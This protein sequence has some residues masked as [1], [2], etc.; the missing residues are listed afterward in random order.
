MTNKIG[1]SAGLVWNYLADHPEAKISE[2]K[3]ALKLNDDLLWMAIGWLAR[4]GQIIF[5]GSG[6]AMQIS[7]A[8]R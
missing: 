5:Q 4:E 6:K 2:I 8:S 1:E 3:K 7:L